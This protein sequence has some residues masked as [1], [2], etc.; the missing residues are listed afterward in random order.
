[1]RFAY[2]PKGDYHIGQ[3]INVNGEQMQ[4]ESS[5]HTGKN[6]IAHSLMNASRFERI[7]CIVSDAKPI[8]GKE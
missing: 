8:E 4:I 6:V 5:S 3:I 7:V 2:I 1:M